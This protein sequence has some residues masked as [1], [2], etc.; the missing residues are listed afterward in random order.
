MRT[1]AAAGLLLLG[2]CILA[3]PPPLAR[4]EYDEPHMGT[5]VRV[6]FYASS[7]EQAEA[8][9]KAAFAVMKDVDDRMSDYK[10][11]SEL[12]RLSAAAG[13]GPQPVSAELFEVLAVSLRTAEVSDG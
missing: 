6:V 7:P 12:S 3:E 11:D 10:P 4:Y 9:R 8:G 13:R 2:G 5:K 1:A